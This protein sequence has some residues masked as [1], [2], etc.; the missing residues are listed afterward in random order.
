MSAVMSG[1]SP[2]LHSVFATTIGTY[3][4]ADEELLKELEASIWMLEDGDEAGHAWCEERGYD[5]YTSYASLD[6]LPV[7]ATAFATL[8]DK[9]DGY[10]A[11]FADALS[12]D[13]S[14][15]KLRLDSLWVNVLAPGG[16]HSSHLHP[17]SVISGTTY[18]A[19]TDGAG[20][21]KFEDPRLGLMMAA[22]PLKATATDASRRFLYRHPAVGDVLL[23]ESWLRHEVMPNRSDDPRL[24]I[25]F[26][27][28]LESAE[29]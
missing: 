11:T 6:D 2:A 10:A 18:V 24:S 21:I 13:L 4:L 1:T 29:G 3:T 8:K 27:Y 19:L 5:G 22:P 14:G 7:R 9:L 17:N 20:A 15:Q 12:W 16:A 28:G 23:W 26:N 25:S